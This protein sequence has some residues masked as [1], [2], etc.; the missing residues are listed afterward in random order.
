MELFSIISSIFWTVYFIIILIST[1]S[2]GANSM[3]TIQLWS[4]IIAVITFLGTLIIICFNVWKFRQE[5]KKAD[6]EIK[7]N[8]REINNILIKNLPMSLSEHDHHLENHNN[9]VKKLFEIKEIKDQQYFQSSKSTL[10]KISSKLERVDK[11]REEVVHNN[12]SGKDILEYVDTLLALNNQLRNNDISLREEIKLK[13]KEIQKLQE[14]NQELKEEL[15]NY[16]NLDNSLE[17]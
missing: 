17:R 14:E 10:E 1:N 16:K 12:I 9:E 15:E 4:F 8:W 13:E 7:E 6:K 3:D 5:Q 2:K 11:I